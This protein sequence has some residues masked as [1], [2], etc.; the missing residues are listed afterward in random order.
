[1]FVNQAAK[2]NPFNVGTVTKQ[3]TDLMDFVWN[4]FA[5]AET[6]VPD[7]SLCSNCSRR[8]Q[9]NKPATVFQP[10]FDDVERLA[11]LNQVSATQKATSTTVSAFQVSK[12]KVAADKTQTKLTS[13]V[14]TVQDAAPA[15]TRTG[16]DKRCAIP[17]DCDDIDFNSA[18]RPKLNSTTRC[19]IAC[20]PSSDQTRNIVLPLFLQH[21]GH[22][23]TI[24]GVE[25]RAN[26]SKV[27]L[28]LDP[29]HNSADLYK[30]LCR[31]VLP[32]VSLSDLGKRD[33]EIVRIDGRA[34][35]S[36]AQR[37]K[38]RVI[39]AGEIVV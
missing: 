18:K 7:Q 29:I 11:W 25:E 4:H 16:D 34:L 6:F 20:R 10:M 38:S 30:Q 36:D 33:Y 8:V 5:G 13:F 1:M 35:M 12:S 24:I 32:R 22:S 19:C 23:R 3:H 28:V 31:G 39:A 15:A 26:G 9:Q 17:V 37:A 21:H 14:T 2:Q 27:L